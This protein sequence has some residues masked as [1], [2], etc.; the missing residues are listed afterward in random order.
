MQDLSNFVIITGC[1]R[2]IGYKLTEK[3]LLHPNKFQAMM[4]FRDEKRGQEA[5]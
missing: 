5:F 1:T 4:T 3:I 2:G